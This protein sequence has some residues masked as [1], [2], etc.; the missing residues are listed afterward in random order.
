[1][2]PG[3]SQRQLFAAVVDRHR[4]MVYRIAF[5]RTR[6]HHDADDVTQDVFVILWQHPDVWRPD[7]RGHMVGADRPSDTDNTNDA[8]HLRF[9]LIR[10]TIRACSSFSRRLR[11]APSEL[12]EEVIPEAGNLGPEATLLRQERTAEVR[13]ALLSLPSGY[14]TILQLYYEFELSTPEIARALGIPKATVRTKL[15]RGR[16]RLVALLEP[17]T[18]KL[19]A[20]NERAQT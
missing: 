10:V 18:T 12:V 5:N 2:D 14:R 8:D 16:R 17:S 15:A 9:W 20:R 1:M 3:L 6:S 13:R 7:D 11:Y 4:D 19:E